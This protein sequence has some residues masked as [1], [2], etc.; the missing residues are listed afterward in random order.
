[1]RYYV[2]HLHQQHW[3]MWSK[4]LRAISFLETTPEER[5]PTFTAL[6]PPLDEALCAA[7]DLEILYTL[8]DASFVVMSYACLLRR[9]AMD[10]EYDNWL[11]QLDAGLSR[12][13]V[14]AAFVESAE[15]RS[16]FERR[17][18]LLSALAGA[19]AAPSPEALSPGETWLVSRIR[20]AGRAPTRA[21]VRR[22]GAVTSPSR[23]SAMPTRAERG[24]PVYMNVDVLCQ[25]VTD[26]RAA[27]GVHR[28]VTNLL[29]EL[30]RDERVILRVFYSP[31]M[32]E[33]A[34]V[35][36]REGGFLA[37]THL[38]SADESPGDGVAFYPYFPFGRSD[39][40]FAGL[41]QALTLC[42]LFPLTHPA[43]FSNVAVK[44]FRR[45]LHALANTDH[46]FCISNSTRTQ[47][48]ECFPTLQA[49]SSVAYLGVGS[50]W[51]SSLKLP[52]PKTLLDRFINGRNRK[53]PYVLCV[54]TIEPRK[55]LRTVLA[56]MSK[57][58]NQKVEDLRLCIVGAEGWLTSTDELAALAG[59]SAD[60]IDFLGRVPDDR[61]RTLYAGAVCTVF[62]SLAEG[63]GFPI[64][65]SLACGTP[66][67]TSNT[68]SMQEIAEKG[69]IL[70][71]PLDVDE[72]AAAIFS[73]YTDRTLRER[74]SSEA[75]VQ[76]RRFTWHQCAEAHV[77]VFLRLAVELRSSIAFHRNAAA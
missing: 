70:V 2:Q 65:E 69:A 49:T 44:T 6:L 25:A 21:E 59:G 47:L 5:K 50:D 23:A 31:E 9:A 74:L 19:G 26:P 17:Y 13:E 43:W 67:I 20:E 52:A 11:Q 51:A 53:K 77:A 3:R 7:E 8:S 57:L 45:Q 4:L 72:I 36:F 73:L 29:A 66:V 30:A 61:L 41:P 1:M 35:L 24:L 46:V 63:F 16:N 75:L 39:A 34:A 48:Q 58:T 68:S 33:N 56:A 14:V 55:N 10:A 64:V 27:T 15:M 37:G 60:R 71:N 32:S 76:A 54:G 22:E 62:P 18:P 42:D 28:Y 12:S 38:A 40:R